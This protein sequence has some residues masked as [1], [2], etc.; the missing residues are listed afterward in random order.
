[1]S[2]FWITQ[3]VNKGEYPE[4]VTG[5]IKK[6]DNNVIQMFDSHLPDNLVWTSLDVNDDNT[7]NI[8]YEFL[9]DNYVANKMY[10]LEYSKEFL[11]WSLTPPGYNKN[12]HLGL[13]YKTS[14]SLFLVGF[15]TGTKINVCVK[16]K[17]NEL[18]GINYLSV[19]KKLRNKN[20]APLLI[21]EISRRSVLLNLE[22]ALYTVGKKITKPFSKSYYKNIFLNIP[23]L[24]ECKFVSDDQTSKSVIHIK[25]FYHTRKMIIDDIDEVYTLLNKFMKKYKV[26]QVF[27]KK[28]ILH[29]FVNDI[30][31]TNVI[32]DNMS[33][34]IIGMYSIYSIK[35]RILFENKHSHIDFSYLHYYCYDKNYITVNDIIKESR[36]LAVETGHDILS[37]L[38]IMDYQ[39]INN[40]RLIDYHT[41]TV[42][43]YYMYNYVCND[44]NPDELGVLLV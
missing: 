10:G 39:S 6:V 36:L 35:S 19:H 27:S 7:L 11:R 24:K 34:R 8:I 21:K 40:E 1:M 29:L 14:S 26:Y 41:D 15:I 32:V 2:K 17:V 16:D 44:I 22:V 18:V 38:N 13:L 31:Y 43:Y 9:K 4:C 12:L 3:L 37:M 25:S 28:E 5:K 20:I 33:K 30:M 23:K 42:L